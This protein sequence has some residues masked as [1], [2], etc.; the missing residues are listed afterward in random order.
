M[1]TAVPVAHSAHQLPRRADYRLTIDG[2]QHSHTSVHP[3][4]A[5]AVGGLA[6]Y[7]EG[8]GF[9]LT[10]TQATD[11]YTPMNCRPSNAARWQP[12]PSAAVATTATTPPHGERNEHT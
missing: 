1:T 10:A 2:S 6:D 8:P 7:A 9:E 11:T 12:L 5:G 3:G 4:R